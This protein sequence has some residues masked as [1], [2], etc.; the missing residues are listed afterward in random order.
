MTLSEGFLKGNFLLTGYQDTSMSHGRQAGHVFPLPA[1]SHS[2]TIQH[3]G[4]LVREKT[5]P[6]VFP[7]AAEMKVSLSFYK[8]LS[9]EKSM[10]MLNQ[11]SCYTG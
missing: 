2:S 1:S 3:A 6:T 7:Q 5:T 4:H 8:F 11:H 10:M 9:L